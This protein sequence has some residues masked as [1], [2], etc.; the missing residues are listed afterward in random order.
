VT[1]NFVVTIPIVVN[2]G[3]AP[4]LRAMSRPYLQECPIALSLEVIGERWTL[5]LIRDLLRFGPR[6]FRDFLDTQ[7]GMTPAVLSSRLKLLE[8][9]G[10][11][12]RRSYSTHPPRDEYL[13]T[14]KG[15]A[16]FPVIT[17]LRRWGA[18]N[19]LG[20][21]T[22]IHTDCQTEIELQPYCPHCEREVGPSELSLLPPPPAVA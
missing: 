4:Y 13:L 22:V 1:S 5:L 19:Y 2:A 6:R 3:T 16:L 14:P 11:I 21:A 8:E 15:S 18:D 9:H 7:P 17:A 12:S 10:V 20:G